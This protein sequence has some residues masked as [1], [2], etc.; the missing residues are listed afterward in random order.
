MPETTTHEAN[1]TINVYLDPSPIQEASFSTVLGIFPLATNSLNGE[2]VV[3]YTSVAE[4][5]ADQTAG[6]LSASAVDF[7]TAQ[8]AQRPKPAEVKIANIDIVGA[9]TYA[10]ALT[11]IRA[12]DDDFYGLYIAS[13]VDADIV[14]VANAVESLE[15]LFACQSDDPSLLDS[16]LPAGLSTLSD[17][18]NTIICYHDSDAEPFDAAYLAKCL[19]TS[20]D[21]KSIP[22]DVGI[23]GV[24]AYADIP[25]RSERLA[26]IANNVNLG[27][28]YGGD[29]FFVDPGKTASGRP[30]YEIVTA[31][32]FAIRLREKLAVLKTTL[33]AAG[34]KLLMTRQG[35]GAVLGAISALL[36]QGVGANHF[37]RGETEVTALDITDADRAAQRL[38][39]EVRAQ[40]AGSARLL[41]VSVYLGRNP[42]A[43]E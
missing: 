30:I 42:I 4:A 41:E 16:G 5:E 31:H 22:W 43:E 17:N 14:A 29:D 23:L 8:F 9:E 40:I 32:W 11:R 27:L 18:D 6:Y 25:T 36:A 19:V 38:R 15:K 7:I 13:R 28:P 1:L 26:A 21:V 2:D 37:V 24:D 10:A 33:S 35:Q 12:V 3:T 20:P 34:E 39:F